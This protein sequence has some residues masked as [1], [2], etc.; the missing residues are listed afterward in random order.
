MAKSTEVLVR[1]VLVN[2]MLVMKVLVNAMLMRKVLLHHQ[3]CID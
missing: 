2:A 3:H 1:K